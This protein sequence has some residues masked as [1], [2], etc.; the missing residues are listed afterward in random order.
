MV[1]RL[2]DQLEAGRL[3]DAAC[4]AQYV[5]GP[6]RQRL[7]A[8]GARE[9]D[10]FVDQPLAD[11]EATRRRLDIEQTQL[12]HLGRLAYDEDRANHLAFAFGDPAGLPLRDEIPD[13]LAKDL[14][15]QRLIGF[16]PAIFLRIEQALAVRDPA[17]V[18]DL[19]RPQDVGHLG[20]GF[21][22]EQVLHRAHRLDQTLLIHGR[23]TV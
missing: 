12:S 15:D 20:F 2:L 23:Q 8:L 4:R 10:A 22:A 21:V 13:E 18:A 7:V 11:A 19:Q 5:V 9:G 1:A 17:D 16:V 6:Q 14:R 3:V